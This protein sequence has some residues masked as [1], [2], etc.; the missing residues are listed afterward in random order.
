MI[1]KTIKYEVCNI[2]FNLKMEENYG[3]RYIKNI[4]F[5]S[6]SSGE[7]DLEIKIVYMFF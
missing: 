5:Y 2:N 4:R 6:S 1:V 3:T 7:K